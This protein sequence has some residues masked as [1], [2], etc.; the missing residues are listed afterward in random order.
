MACAQE[1]SNTK[2]AYCVDSTGAEIEICSSSCN[3]S[4][5]TKCSD[6]S[7]PPCS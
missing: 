2:N 4:S 1:F 6:A 7:V 3:N 5:L